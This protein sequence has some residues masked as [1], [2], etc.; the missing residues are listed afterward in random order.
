MQQKTT[1]PC[2]EGSN[3]SVTFS[4]MNTATIGVYRDDG[5]LHV[6]ATLN[7]NDR[8]MCCQKFQDLVASTR[9]A[10][11]GILADDSYSEWLVCLERQD[12]PDFVELES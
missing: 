12:T 4:G 9:E 7:N 5:V 11:R 2:E 1:C 3:C 6:L 10:I 8:M